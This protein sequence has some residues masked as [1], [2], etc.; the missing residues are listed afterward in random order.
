MDRRVVAQLYD[1]IDQIK[2][3]REAAVQ[4][5]N[6]GMGSIPTLQA[7]EAPCIDT[8]SGA[9][10]ST[11]STNDVSSEPLSANAMLDSTKV[12]SMVSKP[13]FVVLIAATN[14]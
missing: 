12:V 2:N 7:T 9:T 4:I 8:I 13:N 5:N 6:T 14:R 1:C 11:E 3:I 10:I